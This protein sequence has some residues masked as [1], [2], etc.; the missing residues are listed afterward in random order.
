[1]AAPDS[2]PGACAAIARTF[3]GEQIF[4]MGAGE[5]RRAVGVISILMGTGLFLLAFSAAWHFFF[6][7]MDTP[8]G[9]PWIMETGF[10]YLAGAIVPVFLMALFLI[11]IALVVVWGVATT[12]YVITAG[13][14]AILAKSGKGKVCDYALANIRMIRIVN[15][16]A[17]GNGDLELHFHQPVR[18][19]KMVKN[20]LVL[21]G[22][23]QVEKLEMRVLSL[24]A[25]GKFSEA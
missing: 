4:W 19:G 7:G 5:I 18:K 6:R 15:L 22:I 21:N 17:D 3:P 12:V 9:L 11:A 13:R 20:K 10:N 8:E 23:P 24:I 14:V 25:D 1:M 2:Y 16:A